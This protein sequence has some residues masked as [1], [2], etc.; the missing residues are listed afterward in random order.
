M[1]QFSAMSHLTNY[2]G[3]KMRLVAVPSTAHTSQ[4]HNIAAELVEI[5]SDKSS[6][7]VQTRGYGCEGDKAREA[8]SS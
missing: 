4:P 1:V 6:L 3:L 2:Y 5:L 8:A 7:V